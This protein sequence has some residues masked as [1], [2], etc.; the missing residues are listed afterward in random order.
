MRVHW[1]GL[2]QQSMKFGKRYASSPGHSC[3][4]AASATAAVGYK[5]WEAA[6]R[7]ELV[8]TTQIAILHDPSSKE[9]EMVWPAYKDGSE[10]SRLGWMNLQI[11]PWACEFLDWKGRHD[12]VP[13]ASDLRGPT[14]FT[15]LSPPRDHTGQLLYVD[16]RD[17][18]ERLCI[19]SF[20]SLSSI[21]PIYQ[22]L[23]CIFS[24]AFVSV[25][26]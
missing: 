24:S 9:L 12:A 7:Y 6:I 22:H 8:P 5:R 13:S 26:A 18:F 17:I 19:L 3:R 4:Y 21:E 20:T 23:R 2:S 16:E 11:A 25:S 1:L 15:F 10:A 14:T